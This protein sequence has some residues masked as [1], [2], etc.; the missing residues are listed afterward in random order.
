MRENSLQG[1]VRNEGVLRENVTE[2][3]CSFL[4][5]L[6]LKSKLLFVVLEEECPPEEMKS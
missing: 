2:H 6:S 4:P 5:F 1:L 3:N